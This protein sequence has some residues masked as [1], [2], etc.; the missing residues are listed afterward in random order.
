VRESLVAQL[1]A[2]LAGLSL[3][4]AILAVVA[5]FRTQAREPQTVRP[6]IDIVELSETIER[7]TARELGRVGSFQARIAT[8]L[9]SLIAAN[10]A[11]QQ[12]E[13]APSQLLSGDGVAGSADLLVREVSHSLGTPLARIRA[14]AELLRTELAQGPN[15][16]F[17]PDRLDRI[18]LAVDL[19]Q[20]LLFAF[21]RL[22]VQTESSP[23]LGSTSLPVAVLSLV[24][25]FSLAYNKTPAVHVDLPD[26][27]PGYSKSFTLAILAPLVENAV[28][29]TT[30]SSPIRVTIDR[31]EGEVR[32]A[33]TNHT[34]SL[35]GGDSIF[36]ASVSTKEGHA[37]LGLP[38]ALLLI[39]SAGGGLTYA[40][41]ADA[42]TFT[43]TL[44]V[45]VG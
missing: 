31:T 5:R 2:A 27:L 20:A 16:D 9:E 45:R 23:M 10:E 37:G 6:R 26:A 35:P 24:R 13:K 21:R 38:T 34:T 1:E 30:T 3:A 17:D 19:C 15:S 41:Q 7:A 25:L 36:R 22:G 39:E 14:E 11:I 8:Q 4:F 42:V 44:P 28:E 33:V 29:A 18:A 43:V 12:R 32:V 40:S